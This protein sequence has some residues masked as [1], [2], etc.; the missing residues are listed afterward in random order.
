M[1][2]HCL[3]EQSGTF[4]NVFKKYGHNAFDYDILNDYNETDNIID[5]FEQIELE[6]S[7]IMDGGSVKQYSLQW[8]KIMTL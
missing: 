3:F 2:F 1:N 7:N 6:Y 4:K 8:I 5:L